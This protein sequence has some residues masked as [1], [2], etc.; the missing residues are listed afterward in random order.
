MNIV[1]SWTASLDLID[2]R[3]ICAGLTRPMSVFQQALDGG[4][5]TGRIA[6]CRDQG[7]IIGW[8]RTERWRENDTL[9]AFVAPCYRGRGVATACAAALLADGAISRSAGVVVFR[10]PMPQI[11]ERLGIDYVGYTPE[12]EEWTQTL[13]APSQ[14]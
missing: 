1:V 3:Y 10:R 14:P 11:A 8:A 12:G 2:R 9:E 4:T 5:A 13:P 6:I 7:E